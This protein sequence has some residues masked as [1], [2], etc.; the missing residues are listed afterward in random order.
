MSGMAHVKQFRALW[1]NSNTTVRSDKY[2]AVLPFPARRRR[3]KGAVK[4]Q[5]DILNRLVICWAEI[6]KRYIVLDAKS[7]HT[8]NNRIISALFY[9]GR[10]IWLGI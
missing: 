9:V 7:T 4:K 3:K 6:H 8:R 2:Y 1:R 5:Q 10:I